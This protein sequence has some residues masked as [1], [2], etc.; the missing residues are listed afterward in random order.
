MRKTFTEFVGTPNGRHANRP[1]VTL[2]FRG[3]MI[4]NGIAHEGL[5]TPSAVTL[6]Y[7]EDE[8]IIALKPANPGRPNAF[9][10][11]PKGQT[12]RYRLI[13]ASPFCKH[14]RIRVDR[15]VTFNDIKIDNEGVML[16]NLRQATSVARGRW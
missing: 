2:N 6:H 12:G 4:L 11:K 7:D 15:T 10:L 5:E 14:F 1:R 9:P 3:V 13:N 8:R 16:L